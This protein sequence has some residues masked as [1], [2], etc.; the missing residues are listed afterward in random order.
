MRANKVRILPFSFRRLFQGEY[1]LNLPKMRATKKPRKSHKKKAQTLLFQADEGH[2]LS[3]VALLAPT[4]KATK[5]NRKS[6]EQ[7]CHKQRK[8]F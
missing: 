6:N 3:V 1:A 8:V 5:K 4:K 7:K 2:G